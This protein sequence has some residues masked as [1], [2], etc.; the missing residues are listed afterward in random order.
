MNLF[1]GNLPYSLKEEDLKQAFG[2]FG[3]VASVAI[4]KDKFTGRSKG[5]GFIDIPDP[6][7]AQSAI[8]GLNGSTINGRTVNVSEALP[9][10]DAHRGGARQA[11]EREMGA[12]I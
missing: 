9:R 11:V 12:R 6:A 2:A 8:A 10:M 4:I 1:I 5:F 7:Q 3:E